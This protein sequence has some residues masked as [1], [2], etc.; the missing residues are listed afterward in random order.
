MPLV[1]ASNLVLSL[2]VSR[3]SSENSRPLG[4]LFSKNKNSK[5]LTYFIY[6]LGCMHCDREAIAANYNFVQMTLS[7]QLSIGGPMDIALNSHLGVPSSNPD[8]DNVETL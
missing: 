6:T 2:N 3:S 4:L 5:K 1:S 7:F 8:W